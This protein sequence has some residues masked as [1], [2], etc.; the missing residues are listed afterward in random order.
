MRHYH[1]IPLGNTRISHLRL[2]YFVRLTLDS[3]VKTGYIFLSHAGN[4]FSYTF[5]IPT[6]FTYPITQY[7]NKQYF[8][9][10]EHYTEVAHSTSVRFLD[11]KDVYLEF[12]G[13][14]VPVTKSGSQPMLT[15]EVIIVCTSYRLNSILPGEQ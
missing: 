11:G 8:R 6:L 1:L 15:F 7:F 13:N 4:G 14:L 3:D 2:A 5:I 9:S 10:Q 12:S